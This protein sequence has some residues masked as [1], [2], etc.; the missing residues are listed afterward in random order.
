[1]IEADRQYEHF[2]LR[3]TPLLKSLYDEQIVEWLA[4][5]LYFFLQ[6]SF[7]NSLA[8]DFN[9]WSENNVQ[10]I[11]YGDSIIQEGEKPL[12]TLDRFLEKYLKGTITGV[13]ILPFSP[14]VL[15]MGLLSLTIYRSILS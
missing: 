10:L 9:K 1:M 14:T 6:G 2:S 8:E 5:K 7:A 15:M 12:V 3:V 4:D 11:T 13:H